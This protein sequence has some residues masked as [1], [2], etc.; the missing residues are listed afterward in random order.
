[1]RPR[2]AQRGFTL[3]ETM[4]VVA[5]TGA[6]FAISYT[7]YDQMYRRHGLDLALVN[8]QESLRRAA[9][10]SISMEGDSSWGVHI[11]E[12]ALTLFKGM[13]FADRDASYDETIEFDYADAAPS[14]YVFAKMTGRPQEDSTTEFTS[15]VNG[16]TAIIHVN[17]MGN[18]TLE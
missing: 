4:L 7:A 15:T 11:A 8:T 1:M 9:F 3:F 5:F 2:R 13:T 17:E 18:V 10:L 16:D 12:N 14:E 6:L